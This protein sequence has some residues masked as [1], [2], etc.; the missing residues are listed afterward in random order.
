[1]T[2]Y[3]CR[4]M[5]QLKLQIQYLIEK[6]KQH[7]YIH[8]ILR[9]VIYIYSDIKN[10][11]KNISEHLNR[12]KNLEHIIYISMNDNIREK[13][14]E[15]IES[16]ILKPFDKNIINKNF[17]NINDSKYDNIVR[18]DGCFAVVINDC[19][20]GFSISKEGM[21]AL[22]ERGIQNK[23]DFEL[24]RTDRTLI[25]LIQEGKVQM[26]GK[27]TN[28]Q[29]EWIEEKYLEGFWDIKEY[30][31]TEEIVVD[32][33]AYNLWK[34]QQYFDNFYKKGLEVIN[35]VQNNDDKIEIL[36]NLFTEIK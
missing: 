10:I 22:M 20:G 16:T 6:W 15:Q 9:Q 31:G 23:C 19:Y 34:K 26:N 3:K 25:E 27:H 33:R 7:H 11:N 8:F 29:I 28:L 12:I 2:Q 13:I 17:E 5:L 35:S 24:D 14:N 1:M 36:R 21:K 4:A 30:D 32:D 18:K